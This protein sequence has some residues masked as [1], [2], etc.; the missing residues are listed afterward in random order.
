[1]PET[2]RPFVSEETTLHHLKDFVVAAEYADAVLT[3]IHETGW[4]T[5]YVQGTRGEILSLILFK[6]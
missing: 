1:M 6:V 4:R 2:Q 3:A 5:S